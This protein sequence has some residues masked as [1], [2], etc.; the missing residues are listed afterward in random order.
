MLMSQPMEPKST[1]SRLPTTS[2]GPVTGTASDADGDAK[3]RTPHENMIPGDDP[4]IAAAVA[5]DRAA[6]SALLR[7]LLPRTRNLVRYLVQGDDEVDDLAQAALLEILRALPSFEGRSALTTWADRITVRET[8]RRVKRRR[9]QLARRRELEERESLVPE[10][11]HSVA[12]QYQ[13]K[14]RVAALLDHLPDAQRQAL[15]LHHVVGMSVPELAETLG[16]PFDT[17]KSRLRLAV[18]RLRQLHGEDDE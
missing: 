9:L 3:P 17:A 18:T 13:A 2:A 10:P 7:V 15:V 12:D 6:A 1:P 14:R 16:I 11:V 5:G 4:R 8:L